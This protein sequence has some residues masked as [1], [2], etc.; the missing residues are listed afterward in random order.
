MQKI[1]LYLLVVLLSVFSLGLDSHQPAQAASQRCHNIE[2]RDQ[3][4]LCLAI[5]ENRSARCRSISSL[6]TR[7]FCLAYIDKNA[8]RCYSIRNKDSRNMCLALVHS[9]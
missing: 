2:E 5:T 4:N 7:Q 9:R 6:D 8:T 3:R 1:R